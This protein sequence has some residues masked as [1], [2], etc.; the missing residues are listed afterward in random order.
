M[1]KTTFFAFHGNPGTLADWDYVQHELNSTKQ[2]DSTSNSASNSTVELIPLDPYSGAWRKTFADHQGKFSIVAHS[3]GCLVALQAAKEFGGKIDRM[4]FV[5]PYVVSESSISPFAQTL[6]RLPLVG[7][8]LLKLNYRKNAQSFIERAFAPTKTPK[9]PGFELWKKTAH[10]KIQWQHQFE[11]I[12]DLPV[13]TLVLWGL[14]D[15]IGTRDIQLPALKKFSA[16][17]IVEIAG[18]GHA[19]PWSA[20]NLIATQIKHPKTK[21]GYHPGANV[22]NNVIAYMD[23]HLKN[24][25]SRKALI[26]KGGEITFENFYHRIDAF[27][28]GLSSIGIKAGDRVIVFLPMSLD[29]YVAMFATQKIGAIAV[30]LDSWARSGHLGASAEC[31]GPKAMISFQ[32]AFELVNQVPEFAS[33][34]IRVL[35]GPG[36]TGTHAFADLLQSGKST[37]HA[38]ESETTALVTFTTGSTGKP[39]GANRTHRF[40]SA[41]HQAL[42]H[43]IPYNQDDIDMPAFPIF[44]LNNLASGVT[45]VLP[46]ID[47]ARPTEHDGKILAEQIVAEKI[48]CTTLSPSMLNSVAKFCHETGLKLQGLRRTVTGGAPISKD[49]VR[50]FLAIAPNTD[51]WVLYG[52]TEAEP[53]AHIEGHEMISLPEPVDPEVVEEGVCVGHISEDIDYKF[54]K[55]ENGPIDIK[56]TPWSSIEVKRGEVGEFLCTGDHVCRDY[57]N[58]PDAFTSTKI[59][60]EDGRVWHRTGDLCYIDSNHRLWMV[61]RVN[62]AIERQGKYYF[63]VRAE[64]I[65]KRLSFTDRCGFL[66]FNGTT[67]AIELK[68]DIDAK[69]FDFAAAK[70]EVHRVFEKNQ[71]PVDHI[72]FVKAIPM[73]PR[74]HSK[75]E[76]KVLKD[77]LGNQKEQILG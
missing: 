20:A 58:N 40:L 51:L 75:V 47:L 60:G 14:E 1:S 21:I 12:H 9:A 73:D 27:A 30:F 8:L 37:T 65:L 35:Y 17:E 11:K 32:M 72:Y 55:I 63:P 7:D 76:Y 39:K 23:K 43:V 26:W 74:H 69:T 41:Q 33:M 22:E 28:A 6:L 71:I 46:A 59:M 5:N 31:V 13:P 57:Y 36:N 48:T 2:S 66:D 67:V 3:M 15:Q 25:P 34:P 64:V 70:K 44:S 50:K 53:M 61:G 49:D 29:M 24:H 10:N 16:V 45:T 52:S 77:I 42:S 19:L 54:I 68:K 56:K 62:N 4:I 38:V 18:H